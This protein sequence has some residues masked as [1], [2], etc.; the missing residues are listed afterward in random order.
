MQRRDARI[1]EERARNPNYLPDPEDQAF[2]HTINEAIGRHV[3]QYLD[4]QERIQ[5]SWLRWRRLFE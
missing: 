3:D 2:A 1:A 5:R 4:R